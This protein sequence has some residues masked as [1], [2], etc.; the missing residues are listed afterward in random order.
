MGALL[1]WLLLLELLGL[2]AFPL[3]YR[4]FSRLPDRGWTLSKPLGLLLLGYGVW[5][6]GLS[7]TIPNSRWSVLLVLVIVAALAYL[8]SRGHWQQMVEFVRRRPYTVLASEAL[9][10]L[11]FLGWA[12]FRAHVPDISHTEQPMDLAL[13]NATVTSPHYPPND[14]WLAGYGVSY[15][16][17]GYLMIG[18]LTMLSGAAVS[19]AYNLGLV[20]VASLGGLAA[21]GIVYNLVRLSRGSERGALF[22][23]AGAAFLLLIASNLEGTLEMAR[24]AGAGW[25]V[26]LELHRDRPAHRAGIALSHVGAGG[27]LVVVPCQPGLRH[28]RISNVQL[29]AGRYAPSRHVH[30]L[31]AAGSGACGPVVPYAGAAGVH[32]AA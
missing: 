25:R 6:L 3:A 26:V 17:L 16:Y 8:A 29:C 32:L 11:L 7:N 2:L 28:H 4:V 12:L 21:F 18:V 20:T 9:F 13:L 15:Y 14:P 23:G 19:V 22:A 31:P 30:P 1:V 5:M 24:A 27:L 10:L